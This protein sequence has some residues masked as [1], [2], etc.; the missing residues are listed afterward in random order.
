MNLS[1]VLA[2]RNLWRQRRR[3]WLTVAAMVFSNV[4]LIFMISV[5][6]GSYT[7]MIDNTLSLSSGHVQVQYKGYLQDQ[8][9]RQSVPEIV[10]LA[11]ALR[12]KH[13]RAEVA[14][15]ASAFALASSEQRS[16]GIQLTGV[17]VAY[18]PQ[19]STFPGL[20]THGRYLLPGAEEEIV[21]GSVLAQNLKVDVGDSLTFIGTGRD[22]SFAAAVATVVGVVTTGMPDLD[23]SVAHIP[24]PWFEQV[25]TMADS[26]HAIVMRLAT[27]EAVPSTVTAVRS[28]IPSN[29]ELVV[30]DWD[31]LQPGL[32]QAI[33]SDMTTAWIMYAVLIV[34]VAFSVLNTQL[35][36]V[37]ERTREFGVMMALGMGPGRLARLV[38]METM[39]M[40]VVG[41]LLGV[42]GGLCVVTYL[43]VHG[44]Y[45]PGMEE[46]AA[47]FNLPDRLYPE[48]SVLALLWGPM[49][50]FVGTLLAAL[51]PA[52]RLF[53]LAPV[54]AMRA[55]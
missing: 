37:L 23:R 35:M 20:V 19:V 7:M 13:P 21:I 15:R 24:F 50:V 22:G 9:M 49:T 4:L 18:E 54:A 2:W 41:L 40:S 30:L 38:L 36:S 43:S 29:G 3:T 11:Q 46:M 14:A 44:F 8:R 47:K 55:V 39:L 1:W 32:R 6:L 28:E 53:R 52:L 48:V 25:F 12:D 51:Y 33:T 42:V 16:F 45:Y 5:Q 31:A 27:L 17:Q 10:A 26:G 34:L